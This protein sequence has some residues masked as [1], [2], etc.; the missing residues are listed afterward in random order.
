M[1]N[2]RHQV[3]NLLRTQ[4]LTKSTEQSNRKVWFLVWNRVFMG[5]R[6]RLELRDSYEK[7]KLQR[8]AQS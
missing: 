2:L 3:W 1:E 5:C 4:I 8:M 6:T 7:L